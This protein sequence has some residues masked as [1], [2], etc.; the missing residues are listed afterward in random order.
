MTTQQ[1]TKFTMSKEAIIGR[2]LL[3]GAAIRHETLYYSELANAV[4][5]KPVE[6]A[7]NGMAKNGILRQIAEDCLGHPVEESLDDWHDERP[8]LTN[9]LRNN[10]NPRTDEYLPEPDS[11]DPEIKSKFVSKGLLDRIV[12]DNVKNTGLTDAD[13]RRQAL[14]Y[15]AFDTVRIWKLW[16]LISDRQ[17]FRTEIDPSIS[18]LWEIAYPRGNA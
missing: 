15:V 17:N 5:V 3:I 13:T 2:A 1:V 16:S 18:E 11:Y 4:R 14:E 8:D 10:K 9:L 7:T 12:K 6:I